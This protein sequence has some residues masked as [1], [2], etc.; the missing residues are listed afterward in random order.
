MVA[1]LYWVIRTSGDPAAIGDRV[2]GEVHRLD[3]DVATSSMRTLPQVVSVSLGPRR[4][5]ANLIGIA[6]LAGLALAVLGVY[7]VTAFA[8][9]RRAR[10]IGIRSTL[11]ASASQI[12]RPLVRAELPSIGAGLV[13]GAVTAAA[14]TRASSGFLFGTSGMESSA[15]LVVGLA[16]GAAALAACYLPVRRVARADP[17]IALRIE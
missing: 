17:L 1:R 13:V 9:G 8:A 6:G 10:E 12:V 15:I 4:F 2:R 11:G 14:V 16:L 5:N 3:K 7:A